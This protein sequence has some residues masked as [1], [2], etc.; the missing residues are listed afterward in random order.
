MSLR[1][2]LSSTT[3]TST[4]LR[5][6]SALQKNPKQQQQITVSVRLFIFSQISFVSIISGLRWGRN[7]ALEQTCYSRWTL[8]TAHQS[9]AR[10]HRQNYKMQ[11]CNSGEHQRRWRNKAL[12][13]TYS[14]SPTDQGWRRQGFCSQWYWPGI[15]ATET[16][17]SRCKKFRL[18]TKRLGVRTRGHA[19]AAEPDTMSPKIRYGM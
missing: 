6:Y 14:Q 3:S 18:R 12:L 15:H 4:R 16:P 1:G 5:T 10:S 13:T 19:S 11:H 17:S 2:Y 8:L 9:A 7:Y